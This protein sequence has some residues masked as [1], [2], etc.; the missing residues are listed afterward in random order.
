MGS[1]VMTAMLHRSV[2]GLGRSQHHR[3]NGGGEQGK[4]HVDLFNFENNPS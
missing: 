3:R 2:V 4:P 1:V